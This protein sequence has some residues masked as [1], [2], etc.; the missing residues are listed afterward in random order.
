MTLIVHNSNALHGWIGA[1]KVLVR[2]RKV[3]CKENYA[4]SLFHL[5]TICS[6]WNDEHT[7]SYNFMN[8]LLKAVR[9]I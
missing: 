5:E 4:H 2:I 8:K 3:E 1:G 9:N 6:F 7:I